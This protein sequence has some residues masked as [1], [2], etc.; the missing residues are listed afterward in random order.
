[1]ILVSLFLALIQFFIIFINLTFHFS[2]QAQ[3]CDHVTGS[4][5]KRT[6]TWK[7]ERTNTKPTK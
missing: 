1:M 5:F 7:F 2:D 3:R 4:L 6:H